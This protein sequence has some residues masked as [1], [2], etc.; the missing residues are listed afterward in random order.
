[1]KH[2]TSIIFVGVGLLIQGC[3]TSGEGRH[4]RHA[5]IA[6]ESA[7]PVQVSGGQNFLASKSYDATFESVV[8]FLKK[9]DYTVESASKDAGQIATAMSITGGWRQTGT[10]VQV[11]LI[12]ESDITT[13][14]KVAATEQHRYKAL[15]TEPWDD[16]KVNAASSAALA[17]EMKTGL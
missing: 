10:R 17:A 13:T 3:G 14:V 15:Q 1:M 7:K 8:T 9:K 5:R 16:P 12:K 4:E 11:T 6:E 2:I